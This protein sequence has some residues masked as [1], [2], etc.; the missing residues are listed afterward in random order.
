M[1]AEVQLKQLRRLAGGLEQCGQKL[2]G[3]ITRLDEVGKSR[4]SKPLEQKIKAQSEFLRKQAGLC[5]DLAAVLEQAGYL[6][7]KTE[8]SIIQAAEPDTNRYQETLQAVSLPEMARIP[9]TLK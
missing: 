1:E 8:V 3:Y 9:V 7:E 5:K 4:Y 6:Y 2:S